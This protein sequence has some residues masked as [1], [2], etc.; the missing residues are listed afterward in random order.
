M[1]RLV[2]FVGEWVS[3]WV[4]YAFPAWVSTAVAHEHST[5]ASVICVYDSSY[6]VWILAFVIFHISMD[7]LKPV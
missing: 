7:V 5:V 2:D 1:V 3:G 6:F 4:H